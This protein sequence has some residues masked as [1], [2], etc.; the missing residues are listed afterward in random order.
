M[1]Y[2]P[3][4]CERCGALFPV[5]RKVAHRT[6]FCPDC[7]VI[8]KKEWMK[9][10]GETRKSLRKIQKQEAEA[11]KPVKKYKN[12]DEHIRALK[13]SGESYAEDQRRQTIEKYARLNIEGGVSNE[14]VRLAE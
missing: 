11:A 12:L 7:R 8:R 2:F 3:K 13:T 5:L 6:R 1:G 9:D 4:K 10:Y 14:K